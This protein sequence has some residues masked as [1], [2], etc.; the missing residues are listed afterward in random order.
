MVTVPSEAAS[1]YALIRDLVNG[2][3]NCMRINC[4]HD[5]PE[6]W[7]RMIRN[8]RRA[9]LELGKTCKVEMD[10]AGPKLRTGPVEPGPAIIKYRPKRDAFPFHRLLPKPLA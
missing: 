5:D 7:S 4:A 9:E 2:G 6:A 8:L 3:M 10:L 1:D